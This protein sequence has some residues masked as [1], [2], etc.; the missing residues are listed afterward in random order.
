MII[1]DL[2]DKDGMGRGWIE[3]I[4]TKKQDGDVGRGKYC[5]VRNEKEW[6]EMGDE[7]DKGVMSCRCR[8][9]MVS[10]SKEGVGG[11]EGNRD[12]GRGRYCEVKNEKS[13]GGGG[14]KK[15]CKV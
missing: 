2:R 10:D 3:I 12:V 7:D 5:Q 11:I 8:G 4:M 15:G 14:R 1:N 9:G 6:G 13:G